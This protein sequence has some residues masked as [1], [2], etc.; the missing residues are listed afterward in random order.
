[1]K[2]KRFWL[3]LGLS[4]A[5]AAM[6]V[7]IMWLM[8]RLG[9]LGTAD[10]AEWVELASGP[11]LLVSGGRYESPE[12]G[13]SYYEHSWVVL[14]AATGEERGRY[15]FGTGHDFLSSPRAPAMLGAAGH[16]VLY[17]NLDGLHLY[18]LATREARSGAALEGMWPEIAAP[19]HQVR[20][21]G[22]GRLAIEGDDKRW[23]LAQLADHTVEPSQAPD[24]TQDVKRCISQHGEAPG[25]AAK[26]WTFQQLP[27]ERHS[28]PNGWGLVRARA[29]PYGQYDEVEPLGLRVPYAHFLCDE[30]TGQTARFASGSML[31]SVWTPSPARIE[32]A[33]LRPDGTLG[34]RWPSE[35]EHHPNLVL[36]A[37]GHDGGFV[38]RIGETVVSLGPDG[39]P[40]WR[41][42]L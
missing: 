9:G 31:L 32:L 21:L 13:P 1:M 16:S 27:T 37:F 18:D 5:A 24:A 42:D 38:V 26:V 15:S 35:V 28:D 22:R 39:Q 40:R 20:A 14:D 12:S 2:D 19:W 34:W 36:E 8:D 7:P 11:A 41:K 4:T 3:W 23:W 29:L 25:D 33:E 10:H 30:R 17:R 6:I